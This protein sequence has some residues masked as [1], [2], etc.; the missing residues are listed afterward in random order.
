MKLNVTSGNDERRKR[1]G[2]SSMDGLLPPRTDGGTADVPT[3]HSKGDRS[4]ARKYNITEW[5]DSWNGLSSFRFPAHRHIPVELRA[6][7]ARLVDHCHKA[8]LFQCFL[9]NCNDNSVINSWDSAGLKVCTLRH[10]R[11]WA[12]SSSQSVGFDVSPR[13]YSIVRRIISAGN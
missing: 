7:F 11:Y 10:P 1:A 13:R 4:D 3:S 6:V 2:Y 5:N 9:C 8:F 12:N